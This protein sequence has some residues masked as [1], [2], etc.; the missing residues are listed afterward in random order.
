MLNQCLLR[1][2]KGTNCP[3]PSQTGD[4]WVG[5]GRQQ[6][7]AQVSPP[8]PSWEANRKAQTALHTTLLTLDAEAKRSG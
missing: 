1:G 6:K 4:L 2:N 5:A 3:A 8:A 7:E